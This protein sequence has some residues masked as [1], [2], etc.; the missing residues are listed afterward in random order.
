MELIR[1]ILSVFLSGE[2][3]SRS[4]EHL[5]AVDSLGSWENVGA[6]SIDTAK[7]SSLGWHGI[8]F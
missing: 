7:R 1:I 3:C 5:P 2:L 6:A 4:V 8:I